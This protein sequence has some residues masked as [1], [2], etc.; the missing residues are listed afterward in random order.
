MSDEVQKESEKIRV[1]YQNSALHRTLFVSGAWAGLTPTGLIQIALF[2][3][4]HPMPEM[5][6]HDIVA[7]AIGPET[8]KLEKRGVIR[9][10]EATILIPPQIAQSLLPLMQQMIDQAE[11][12]RAAKQA[13]TEKA[14]DDSS[15]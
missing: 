6:T 2:N 12:L 10:V 8:D 5:V 14:S 3:D 15:N 9:E 7:D 1:Y 11:T 4:L 13:Q